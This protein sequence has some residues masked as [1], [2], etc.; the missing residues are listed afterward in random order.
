MRPS[1]SNRLSVI[2]ATYNQRRPLGLL[3]RS[4]VAQR[5]PVPLEVI[6]ADDGSS[7]GTLEEI[8][9]FAASAPLDLRYVW[10]PD[11]G[12]RLARARNNAIRC[13][14]GDLLL[15][16]DG[17]VAL[18]P[19][20]L[21]AHLA[22]H[23][24]DRRVVCSTRRNVACDDFQLQSGPDQFF[25]SCAQSSQEAEGPRQREFIQGPYPWMALVG[26][27]FSI[28]NGPEVLFDEKI[29]GWGSE[30]RELAIRLFHCHGYA[31]SCPDLPPVLH[32]QQRAGLSHEQIVQALR[33]K[34]YVRAKHPDLDITPF[35]SILRFWHLDANGE[36]WSHESAQP[37]ALPA[38]IARAEQW[39]REND[40]QDPKR[41]KVPSS[42]ALP[43]AHRRLAS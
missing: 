3:L 25:A 6:L 21:L 38:L 41:P 19:D 34:F 11:A 7:D 29:V 14:T 27:A 5:C 30:D 36:R 1:T 35:F 22:S 31:F 28:R 18:P 23:E 43:R 33:N 15:F 17:D 42:A 12:F 4:L 20:F 26:F 10:Q 13:A 9:A 8:R 40:A 37:A 24:E 32:L 39:L 16:L 2:I